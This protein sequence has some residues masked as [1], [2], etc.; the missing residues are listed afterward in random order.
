VDTTITSSNLWPLFKHFV[1]KK[2]QRARADEALAD[3]LLQ[4]GDASINEPGTTRMQVPSDMFLKQVDSLITFRFGKKIAKEDSHDAAI[5]CPTNN[6]LDFV[7]EKVLAILLKNK[8]GDKKYY[9]ATRFEVSREIQ[10]PNDQERLHYSQEYLN[11]LQ[12]ASLPPHILHLIPGA[13]VMLIRNVRVPGG[14]CNGTRMK[15]KK[16]YENLIICEIMTGGQKGET[17]GMFRI[18]FVTDEFSLPGKVKRRQFPLKLSYALTVNK[19][20]NKTQH[21]TEQAFSFK[22]RFGLMDKCMLH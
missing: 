2:N 16:L 18:N 10:D 13:N 19:T 12:C 1:L 5:L 7:T 4:V 6:A 17:A 15:V 22:L 3:W 8:T 20:D 21:L 9:S 14:L 11:C